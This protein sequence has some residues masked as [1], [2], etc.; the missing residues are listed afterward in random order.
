MPGNES[1]I[2]YEFN[3]N[4]TLTEMPNETTTLPTTEVPT[5]PSSPY[6]NNLIVRDF[7]LCDLKV[8]F[9]DINC[10]CDEDCNTEDRRV[11]SH[12]QMRPQNVLDT[13]YCFQN[14]IIFSNHTEYKVEYLQNG[15][16]CIVT[17]NLPQ[18][19]TYSTVKGATSIDEYMQLEKG[20]RHYS[21]E[22][23]VQP[24]QF[25][26]APYSVGSAVWAV[27]ERGVLFSLGIPD[28][29]FGSECETHEYLR[30]L[31]DIHS[32]CNRVFHN[33]TDVCEKN[34]DFSAIKYVS[35]YVVADPSTFNQ[36]SSMSVTTEAAEFTSLV[37][38]T[39]I[40][41]LGESST[42][43]SSID[44]EELPILDESKNLTVDE[45]RTRKL[46]EISYINKK[47]VINAA[48]S[49]VALDS[50][51]LSD[52]QLLPVKVF[53]CLVDDNEERCTE[54]DVNNIPQPV[55]KSGV[56]E[57]VALSINYVFIHNGTEGIYHAHA[58]IYL[59]TVANTMTYLKQDFDTRFIWASVKNNTVFE[60]S[61]HP[62][63]IIGRPILLGKLIDNVTDEGE[64]KEA[65]YLDTDPAQWLTLLNPGEGKCG[66]RSQVTFGV[67]MRTGCRVL[68][69]DDDLRH[70][71][72]LQNYFLEL[73]LGPVLREASK[74]RIG[75][76]GDS[77]VN[78]GADWIP[79]LIPEEPRSGA[80]SSNI[81]GKRKCSDLILSVHL[82]I[83]YS[84]QGSL[85]NPQAKIVGIVLRYGEPQSITSACGSQHCLGTHLRQQTQAV[86][87]SS[88][89]SFVEVT[90]PPEP[91]YSRPPTL[92][93]KLPHNFFY[94]FL[95]SSALAVYGEPLL[96]WILLQFV[97][98]ILYK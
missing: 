5:T 75:T 90:R 35:F 62:G 3:S 28:S 15:L 96:V 88:S 95:P 29:L 17:D 64:V 8:E 84:R 56:C 13:R 6:E 54:T 1:S 39:S 23:T 57:N 37:P 87:L 34:V 30:F 70:C 42:N 91:A 36:S 41:Q 2:D 18:H 46:I 44:E 48:P 45:K 26:E 98:L 20:K 68:V 61:G 55:Y 58:R 85:A 32:S 83:A 7:C 86:E 10:C 52:G 92:D 16:L 24:L 4:N 14:Q 49:N 60:R 77:S 22:D 74:L 11:F 89:V 12:C 73:L 19:T 25:N 80:F 66:S 40:S 59:T 31:E 82:E 53:L 81:H 76:Y 65:I 27:S 67:D 9:C 50:K 69:K 97:L 72:V 47:L 21:W 79:I 78:N 93:V 43:V 51:Y 33:V 94:P 63:Y 71:E 38:Q